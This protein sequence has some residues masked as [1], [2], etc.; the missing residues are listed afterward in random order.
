MNR[1]KYHDG[2][3]VGEEHLN[4]TEESKID[5]IKK[6][7]TLMGTTG[8]VEGLIVAPDTVDPLKIM[9]TQGK[10]WTYG[11]HYVELVADA[12]QV[13]IFNSLG[14]FNYVAVKVTEEEQ[15]NL[16]HEVS[17]GM[18]PTKIVDTYSVVVLS[19]AQWIALADKSLYS[20]LA[21]VVGSGGM[22][23]SVDITRSSVGYPVLLA[24][25]IQSMTGVQVTIVSSNTSIGNGSLQ[26]V[27]LTKT[28]S[29]KAPGNTAY[30]TG[31]VIGVSGVYK[32]WDELATSYIKVDINTVDLPTNDTEAVIEVIN[33]LEQSELAVG[34]M[35]DTLHRGMVGTGAPGSRNPHGMT[36]DDLDPGTV[37]DLVAHR[38]KEHSPGIL[39]STLSST[40]QVSIASNTTIKIFGTQ[41]G[42]MIISAGAMYEFISDSFFS[43]AG[44]AAGTYWVWM[45]S[46][47]I[48]YATVATPD[49]LLYAPLAT[50]VWDGTILTSLVDKRRWGNTSLSYRIHPD[51]DDRTI[52]ASQQSYSAADSLAKIRGV[53][54]KLI[55]DGDPN[56]LWDDDLGATLVELLGHIQ[57]NFTEGD[58]VHGVTQGASGGLDADK[59][60]GKH[61]PSGDIVGTTDTQTL[62]GKT[63]TAPVIADFT[64]AAHD[65]SV[66][67]KGG[68][69]AAQFGGWESRA[70]ETVYYA[71]T[72][73]IVCAY[74]TSGTGTIVGYSDGG[75]P[76]TTL[77]AVEDNPSS[78]EGVVFPVRKGDYWY[79]H[80]PSYALI[81]FWLPLGN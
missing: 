38:L 57:L 35:K 30:G 46:A 31:Q 45:G 36:L 73:G 60:D 19:E 27:Q 67:N 76:P 66:A 55:S 74:D 10:G 40:G 78:F 53:L 8:P 50:V 56:V 42:E 68:K 49:L 7:V 4:Y 15:L 3:E 48:V 81:V 54:W 1:S 25:A 9:V 6:I 71:A 47:A 39:G 70:G 41:S 64:S 21:I 62:S 43:F 18:Y 61:A 14:V 24:V 77:R 26:W 79:V 65:H 20:L 17:G 75:S 29:W 22:V 52:P 12:T 51:D 72:D 33:L 34:T 5:I 16:P 28:L 69:I 13:T 37:Q 23:R 63:L 59:V 80:N 2:V 58:E 11:G 44:K 32:L